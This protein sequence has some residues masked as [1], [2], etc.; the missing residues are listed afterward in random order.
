MSPSR[1]RQLLA[2]PPSTVEPTSPVVRYS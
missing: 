1:I 2:R